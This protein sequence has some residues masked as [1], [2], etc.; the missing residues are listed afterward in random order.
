MAQMGQS[1]VGD[2]TETWTRERQAGLCKAFSS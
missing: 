1:V 2:P